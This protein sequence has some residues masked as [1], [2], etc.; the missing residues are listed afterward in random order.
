MLVTRRCLRHLLHGL[1]TCKTRMGLSVQYC[2]DG[3]VSQQ[4]GD[5]VHY[6]V[7]FCHRWQDDSRDGNCVPLGSQA[8]SRL[9][10][11]LKLGC[12]YPYVAQSAS[13]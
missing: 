11:A 10:Q 3:S 12:T 7:E 1:Q 2:N 13:A 6:S 9:T 8:A 5:C 4:I